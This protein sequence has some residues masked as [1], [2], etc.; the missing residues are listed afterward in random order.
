MKK[1]N[2]IVV[3][4]FVLVCTIGIT[5]YASD[6]YRRN[7]PK[8]KIEQP[9]IIPETEAGKYFNLTITYKNES[10]SNAYD[11]TITPDFEGMPFVFEKPVEYKRD[12][13]LRA[14]KSDQY[15]FSFRISDD[16]KA[17]IYALK[18][19]LE[20]TNLNDETFTAEQKLYFKI[21]KEMVKPILNISDISTGETSIVAGEKFPLTFKI[22]NRGEVEAN[23]VE[24]TLKN[25]SMD[26]FMAVDSN[27]YKFIGNLK[28]AESAFVSFDMFASSKIS[29]GP[30]SIVAEIKCKDT[31][32][33]EMT[34]EKTIYISN[35]L[36]ENEVEDDS[37]SNSRPKIIIASY[38]T[39]PSSIVAGKTF[40]FAFTFKNTSKDKKLKN[41]KITLSSTDGAFIITKG[42]NT[43]Y[44]ENVGV[45]EVLSQNIELRAKQDL[46]SNSYPLIINFEYEDSN[47]KEYT[48]T[49]TINI[50]VT[51][52]SKLEIN[53][54]YSN[55][56]V[57]GSN[58][59]LSFSYVNMGKA[60]V[61]NLTASV[62]GDYTSV[63]PI[64]YIGNCTAGTYDY[65]DIE[66]TPTKEGTNYGTLVL[67]F[68]D[69]SGS[70]IEVRKEFEGYAMEMPSYEPSDDYTNP[71]GDY[72]IEMP[73]EEKVETWVIVVSGIGAF[74]VAYF[75][76]R[77][78]T[79]KVVRKKLEDEI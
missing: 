68:E 35:V 72:M 77:I 3:L 65:Y 69:S 7:V 63:Q 76:T 26:N 75:I 16:A 57:L 4:T 2:F 25:M 12:S 78:I 66:V 42:S 6:E 40:N 58:T 74:I 11:L 50:P 59:S 67:S 70:V 45:L 71:G 9:E 49:E 53:S 27:D 28:S 51:E 29:K 62:E 55:D 54:V 46:A 38:S 22:T 64:N 17:G 1:V 30:N 19:N 34:V 47:G 48:A 23:N 36:S 73:E 79:T 24:V 14:R 13:I 8:V 56:T 21:S 43:F 61:S 41:M 31:S 60:T 10:D 20:Y 5:V 15:S 37:N 32:G 52:Y 33:N 39:N 44:V 18:F